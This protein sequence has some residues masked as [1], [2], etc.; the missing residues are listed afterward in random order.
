MPETETPARGVFPED[1]PCI[2]GQTEGRYEEALRMM[3]AS[4]SAWT[5][6]NPEEAAR[7]ANTPVPAEFTL[8]LLQRVED[9]LPY[10][11]APARHHFLARA[12]A[13]AISAHNWPEYLDMLRRA[14]DH[15]D[16][17]DSP[18]PHVCRCITEAVTQPWSR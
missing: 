9:D 7:M 16:N 17:P 15:L 10:P 14:L 13:P 12:H 18:P 6:E 2:T 5:A 8:S 11:G 1:F 4:V 3:L